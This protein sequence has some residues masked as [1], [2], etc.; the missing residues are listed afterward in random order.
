MLNLLGLNIEIQF[1]I[2]MSIKIA[3]ASFLGG[4]IGLERGI[5]GRAAGLRTHLFVSLGSCVFTVLSAYIAEKYGKIADPTRIAAQIVTGIGFLGAGAI[6][7]EGFSIRGLTTA[8]SLW[9][10]AAIGM[11]CGAGN[12][13]LAVITTIIAILVLFG[14]TFIEKLFKRDTR[15]MI[16]I[17]TSYD[18]DIQEIISALK[19]YK[20][21]VLYYEFE[22]NFETDLTKLRISIRFYQRKVS[23]KLYNEIVNAIK[24]S[25]SSVKSIKV[26]NP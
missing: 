8:A 6:I 10:T 14:F 15:K 4:I 19:K 22:K 12:Y 21:K 9:V 20:M 24:T 23:D 16:T 17:T 3:L 25:F 26:H 18:I 5:Q 7:K 13:F 1:F 2:I 11:A